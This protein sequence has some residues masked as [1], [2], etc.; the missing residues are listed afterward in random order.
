MFKPGMRVRWSD[1]YIE[2]VYTGDD[3]A[4]QDTMRVLRKERGEIISV[5]PSVRLADVKWDHCDKIRRC[6]YGNI[7]QY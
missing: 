6:A 4:D 2:A 7:K 3:N 5:D 1:A